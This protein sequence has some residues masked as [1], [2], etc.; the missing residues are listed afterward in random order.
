LGGELFHDL[1]K[2]INDQEEKEKIK[3]M[4]KGGVVL[5]KACRDPQKH[6]AKRPVEITA[7]VMEEYPGKGFACDS[8]LPEQN[9]II[10]EQKIIAE[11]VEI[12][13]QRGQQKEKGEKHSLFEA[14]NPI[15]HEIII[16]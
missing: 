16:S 2:E 14:V 13:G 6:M 5:K 8:A 4:I 12:S 1:E 7:L 10:V 3:N 9:D 15:S 11:T